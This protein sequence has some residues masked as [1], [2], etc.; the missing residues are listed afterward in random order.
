MMMS[1]FVGHNCPGCGLDTPALACEACG[2]PV[3]WAHGSGSHCSACGQSAASITCREC[4]L[5]AELDRRDG[6]PRFQP[7]A[8]AESDATDVPRHRRLPAGM[9]SPTSP[10]FQRLAIV[11]T[12]GAAVLI[13]VAVV[14]VRSVKP[15]DRSVLIEGTPR[16]GTVSGG[17]V[18]LPVPVQPLPQ[19]ADVS[20]AAK[21]WLAPPPT[22][23]IH[24]VPR[25]QPSP[26]HEAGRQRTSRT[27][28]MPASGSFEIHGGLGGEIRR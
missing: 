24:D 23:F 17:T 1:I 27:G 11:L 18:L 19:A 22:E 28:G 26:R 3:T 15:P 16:P 13:G 5:K 6:E 7:A 4:G 2:A 20:P 14:D 12:V 9:T 25:P 21:P 8:L 10:L